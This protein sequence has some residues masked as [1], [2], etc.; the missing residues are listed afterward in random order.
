MMDSLM[1]VLVELKYLEFLLA[2]LLTLLGCGVFQF[3]TSIRAVNTA[4]LG[5]NRLF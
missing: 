2:V 3:S 5:A 1:Q 4:E